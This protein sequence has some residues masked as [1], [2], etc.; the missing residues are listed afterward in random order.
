MSDNRILEYCLLACCIFFASCQNNS[1][2][3]NEKQIISEPELEG[4]KSIETQFYDFTK[5]VE[6]VNEL[7][8]SEIADSVE[9]IPIDNSVM[10]KRMS[11]IVVNESNIYINDL[12]NTYLFDNKGKFIKS[13]YT[14]GRGPGEAYG[15]SLIVDESNNIY[16][17]S[18]W[19]KS[20][21]IYSP[22]G[23]LKDEKKYSSFEWHFHYFNNFLIFSNI[24]TPDENLF[25]V[26]R[27]ADDSLIYK[28]PFRYKHLLR[29]RSGFGGSVWFDNYQ[30]KLFFKE[31]VCDTVYSTESFSDFAVE[32]VFNFGKRTFKPE[33]YYSDRLLPF[34]NKEF[35][36]T[37]K[38][39]SN[40]IIS[41]G[42]DNGE[43][44]MYLI[45]KTN[46][47]IKQ[48]FNKQSFSFPFTNDIDGGSI[49]HFILRSNYKDDLMYFYIQPFELLE[50]KD[51]ILPNSKLQKVANECR[52][53]DNPILVKAYLKK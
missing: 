47:E 20:L 17:G 42:L 38:V 30:G 33:D 10:L 8:L 12:A 31:I 37:F 6:L 43:V 16:V 5:K 51:K 24:V 50:N 29:A 48:S 41:T 35:I 11:K 13:L 4:K 3:D 46:G 40:S 15:T 22:I 53:N 49:L 23:V 1:K 27:I 25:S 39:T 2:R 34:D 45:N 9:Y 26:Y 28:H 7:K 18:R 19:T 52:T 32:Y 44:C 36:S 21:L 14:V